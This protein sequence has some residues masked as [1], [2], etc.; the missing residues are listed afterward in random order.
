[1]AAPQVTAQLDKTAYAPG[2]LMTLT[3]DHADTDRQS[4]TVSVTVTDSTG[5]T[6]TAQV[7]T[8][9]DQGTVTVTSSPAKVWT[10]KA[11]ATAGRSQFT[12]TA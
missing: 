1:M 12:A 3:V 6:G 5:A 2:E 8:Q 9:I 4:L 7:T 11:G 10:L